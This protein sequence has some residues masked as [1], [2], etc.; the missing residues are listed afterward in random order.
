M[1]LSFT[2]DQK[3]GTQRMRFRDRYG[4]GRSEGGAR[5]ISCYSY[6]PH[7]DA[8]WGISKGQINNPS[9]IDAKHSVW[10]KCKIDIL[11]FTLAKFNCK[12]KCHCLRMLRYE[13]K[14][15]QKIKEKQKTGNFSLSESI[16]LNVFLNHYA[17]S[18]ARTI[19]PHSIYLIS[20]PLFYMR[21]FFSPCF[22]VFRSNICRNVRI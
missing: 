2:F 19:F 1:L 10:D 8:N 14:H 5:I 4:I 9:H 7:P 22:N 3:N 20:V 21:L 18:S 6:E 16:L 15:H 13:N 11:N 17:H 12:F